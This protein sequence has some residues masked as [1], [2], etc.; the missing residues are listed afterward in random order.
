MH[1]AAGEA[2]GVPTSP[3]QALTLAE[4]QGYYALFLFFSFLLL[5]RSSCL[6]A[7]VDVSQVVVV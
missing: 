5:R 6:A 3:R 1:V 4:G 7:S 2:G